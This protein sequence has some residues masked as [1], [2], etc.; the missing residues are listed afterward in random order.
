MFPTFYKSPAVVTAAALASANG[1]V[2]FRRTVLRA[3]GTFA[4]KNDLGAIVFRGSR[5]L[6]AS[7]AAAGYDVSV[8]DGPAPD[9]A[10]KANTKHHARTGEP[11]AWAAVRCVGVE[12]RS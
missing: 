10:L 2:S 6:V 9:D 8:H 5:E 1:L 12:V 3:G 7:I 4:G 11:T